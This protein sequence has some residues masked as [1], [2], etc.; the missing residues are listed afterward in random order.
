MNI[1]IW[2][3]QTLLALSM[4]WA[5]GMKFFQPVEKLSALWPWTANNVAL[6]KITGVL[7]LLAGIG[8]ILPGLL[9]FHPKLTVYAAIGTIVLM[10]AASIFH[11]GR[12][13][14]SQIGVN[15]VF[16]LIAAFIVWGRSSKVPL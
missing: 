16:A 1:G 2:V 11:I 7:D 5:A 13:E 6:V 8:L 12:G 4:I 3:A 10:I 15:I 14:A 9:H